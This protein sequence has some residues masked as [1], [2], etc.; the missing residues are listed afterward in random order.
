MPIKTIGI[1]AGVVITAIIAG[2]ITVSVLRNE[3]TE[4]G[5]VTTLQPTTPNSQ[6][7]TQPPPGVQPTTATETQ[8]PTPFPTGC[9][10]ETIEYEKLPPIIKLDENGYQRTPV[11]SFNGW[12]WTART[13]TADHL[14]KVA[15]DFIQYGYKDA[16]Y[17]YIGWDGVSTVKLNLFGRIKLFSSIGPLERSGL[18]GALANSARS[19]TSE[20]KR[21]LTDRV[22][23]IRPLQGGYNS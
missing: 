19:D 9:D 4:S 20:S 21:R 23:S 7:T 13:W 17:D 22:S 6:P 11:M 15:D 2:V 16:G 10:Q 18:D 1:F 14:L 3:N 5:A 8:P 12:F